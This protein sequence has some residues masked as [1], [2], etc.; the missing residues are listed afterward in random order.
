MNLWRLGCFC[1]HQP[2]LLLRLKTCI[3][4]AHSHSISLWLRGSICHSHRPKTVMMTDESHDKFLRKEH[5]IFT[6]CRSLSIWQ[7]RMPFVLSSNH[8]P[9]AIVY[10]WVIFSHARTLS[11]QEL[12]FRCHVFRVHGGAWNQFLTPCFS[13]YVDGDRGPSPDWYS[14]R[15]QILISCWVIVYLPC[16]LRLSKRLRRTN[17]QLLNFVRGWPEAMI[18]ISNRTLPQRAV[19]LN[20]RSFGLMSCL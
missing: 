20:T 9:V 19:V 3:R 8:L 18:I 5:E 10:W 12:F 13:S 14:R 1:P 4:N 11:T 7:L 6:L 2:Q 17:K 16:S 15:N